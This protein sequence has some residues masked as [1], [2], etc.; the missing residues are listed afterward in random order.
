MWFVKK[1]NFQV[2]ILFSRQTAKERIFMKQHTPDTI[3][4]IALVGHGGS[5]KTSLA[6]QCYSSQKRRIGWGRLL[7]EILFVIMMQR[8]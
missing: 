6:R 8:K 4:N 7:T 2:N 5:G 3:K 1:N